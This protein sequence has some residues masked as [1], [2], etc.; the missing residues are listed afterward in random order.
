MHDINVIAQISDLKE[1]DYRNTLA[2]SALIELLIDKGFFTRRE[3]TCKAQE[4]D[5]AAQS[6][7]HRMGVRC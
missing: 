6:E 3:F 4:L 1:V 2:I 7:I 5:Q